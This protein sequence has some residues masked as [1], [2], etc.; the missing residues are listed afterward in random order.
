MLILPKNIVVFGSYY[1]IRG[2]SSGPRKINSIPEWPTTKNVR[3]VRSFMGMEGYYRM[4][5]GNF[6]LLQFIYGDGRLLSNV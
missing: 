3:D 2:R 6:S 5:E 4:S 1:L